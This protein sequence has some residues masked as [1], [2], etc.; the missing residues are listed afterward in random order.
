MSGRNL[1][2]NA[3]CLVHT[4]PDDLPSRYKAQ[5]YETEMLT[6]FRARTNRPRRVDMANETEPSD[7]SVRQRIDTA[8]KQRGCDAEH[9]SSNRYGVCRVFQETHFFTRTPENFRED[10]GNT[11]HTCIRCL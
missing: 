9:A 6:E 5:C 8:G 1:L 10:T 11:A 7:P 3:E 4:F 2:I